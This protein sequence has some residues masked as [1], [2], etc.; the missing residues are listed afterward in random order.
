M[1]TH[2]RQG[3]IS[4]RDLLLREA[5]LLEYLAT[6]LEQSESLVAVMR[7]SYPTSFAQLS[8]WATA[9]VSLQHQI[10]AR[11]QLL[12]SMALHATKTTPETRMSYSDATA[13]CSRLSEG[14]N[15]EVPPVHMV[16][17]GQLVRNVLLLQR[18][19]RANSL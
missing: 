19:T 6:W 13:I 15:N 10:E 2:V 14:R 1:G 17:V 7:V 9:L 11:S 12:S 8:R 4:P 5:A 18:P 3:R 16:Q